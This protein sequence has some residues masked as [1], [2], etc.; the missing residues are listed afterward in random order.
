MGTVASTTSAEAPS[1]SSL[2]GDPKSVGPS[3]GM[4]PS[5]FSYSSQQQQHLQQQQHHQHHIQTHRPSSFSSSAPIY[6][7]SFDPIKDDPHFQQM[8]KRE[9]TGSENEHFS[10]LEIRTSAQ[11]LTSI[12]TQH[13]HLHQQQQQHQHQQQQQYLAAA[14]SSSSAYPLN[15]P[16]SVLPSGRHRNL[17]FPLPP[18][19]PDHEFSSSSSSSAIDEASARADDASRSKLDTEDTSKD[20]SDS[21]SDQGP[22]DVP[23]DGYRWRKYGRKKVKGTNHP[24]SYYKCRHPLCTVKKITETNY[25]NGKPIVTTSYKGEHSHSAPQVIRMKV[26]DQAAFRHNIIKKCQ[27]E[28]MNRYAP[29]QQTS[30]PP[31]TSTEDAKKSERMNAPRLVVEGSALVINPGDDGYHWRKYGQKTVSVKGSPHP[32]SYYKCTEPDCK[33]KKQVEK[34]ADKLL[35]TYDGV[36]IHAIRSPRQDRSSSASSLI[37]TSD[38]DHDQAPR[39]R[40]KL[41]DN[42]EEVTSRSQPSDSPS[43]LRPTPSVPASVSALNSSNP[44]NNNSNN[45]GP[46]SARAPILPRPDST[47]PPHNLGGMPHPSPSYAGQHHP[48]PPPGHFHP[49]SATDYAQQ[50]PPQHQ[51]GLGPSSQYSDQQHHQQL[52]QQQQQQQY[53]QQNKQYPPPIQPK[54]ST[55]LAHPPLRPYPPPSSSSSSSSGPMPSSGSQ[56]PMYIPHPNGSNG[57]HKMPSPPPSSS[58]SSQMSHHSVPHTQSHSLPGTSQPS[59]LAPPHLTPD[60]MQFS[61]HPHQQQQQHHHLSSHPFALP[62]P[63][64]NQQPQ[65]LPH[66]SLPHHGPGGMPFGKHPNEIYQDQHQHHLQQQQQHYQ[67]TN[68]PRSASP[69]SVPH[70]PPSAQ[71]P[72][73]YGAGALPPPPSSS[74]SSRPGPF[75]DDHLSGNPRPL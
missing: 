6:A 41:N 22:E 31:G 39:K 53:Q 72:Q 51:Y 64:Q 59:G 42:T 54:S 29:K 43:R 15:R 16:V 17:T 40:R 58:S 11:M 37:N 2:S 3:D 5:M 50:P 45:N 34:I 67:N 38:S 1:T 48:P 12:G 27:F 74:P 20:D 21:D 46:Q 62:H 14:S 73:G 52:Q 32:R 19:H 61:H 60:Q 18:T 4:A 71:A 44:N 28:Y 36:H 26:L 56:Q 25:E 57:S 9:Q 8:Y 68:Y 75:F 24:R 33:V 49:P 10:D 7:S 70:L 69:S 63:L 23:D 30:Y 66:P 47:A 55:G 13:H 65:H 35:C